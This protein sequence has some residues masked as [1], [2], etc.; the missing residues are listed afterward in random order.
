ML[1][2]LVPRTSR[3][4]PRRRNPIMPTA[5]HQETDVPEVVQHKLMACGE[6]VDANQ[7]AA[8]PPLAQKRLARAPAC[9]PVEQAAFRSLVRWLL[10]TFPP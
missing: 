6:T 9:T 2:I 4:L 5:Q 8:L 10:S 1:C 7:W 3:L